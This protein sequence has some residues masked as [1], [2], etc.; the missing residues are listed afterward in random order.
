[1]L[2]VVTH[3]FLFFTKKEIWFYSGEPIMEGT[4]T[5]FCYVTGKFDRK[6]EQELKEFTTTIDLSKSQEE[7]L[8]SINTTFKYHIRKGKK[9]NFTHS[10]S[11]NPSI[12]ECEKLIISFNQFAKF[13]NILPINKRRVYAL[14]KT[15]NIAFT[16]ISKE[17]TDLV[18]HVYIRDK[19]R[20]LLM[21]TFHNIDYNQKQ[22]RGYAN[23]FLHWKDILSFKEMGIKTYDFGGINM[24]KVP[25]ISSFKLSYGG[26][27]QPVNS[28][29]KVAPIIKPIFKLYKL[30]RPGI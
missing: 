25:G 4:Y 22:M 21:H 12:E 27:I 8:N 26:E 20:V 23:K 17:N 10:F 19:E 9:L 2:E 29:I 30:I 3:R 18:T 6:F 1:M 15:K 5:T 7:L 13:K 24:E 11:F 16:K 14:Q 28:Y